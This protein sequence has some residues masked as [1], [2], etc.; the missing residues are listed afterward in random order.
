MIIYSS[1]QS[2]VV[3]FLRTAQAP[4]SFRSLP[5]EAGGTGGVLTAEFHIKGICWEIF[6]FQCF[7]LFLEA[8]KFRF[9]F[10]LCFRQ[11]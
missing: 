4:C 5:S 7:V 2:I 10:E 8:F 9:N 1:T 11:R 6:T 3:C